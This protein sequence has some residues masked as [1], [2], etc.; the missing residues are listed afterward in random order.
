[1]SLF[2]DTDS[3]GLDR[4]NLEVSPDERAVRLELR[5]RILDCTGCEL[6]TDNGGPVPFHGPTPAAVAVVGEAPGAEETKQGRPFIGPAG[7]LLREEMRNAGIDPDALFWANTVSCK[8]P[9]NPT[10]EHVNACSGNLT[11][12]LELADPKWVLLVGGVA[13]GAIRPDL[14]VSKMRGHC[15]HR[16][17]RVYYSLFHPAFILRQQKMRPRLAADLRMFARMLRE[18]NPLA[19]EISCVGCGLDEEEIGEHDMAIHFDAEAVP[20]CENCVG[21]MP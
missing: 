16:G 20:Y 5:E 7:E 10:G 18:D 21:K 19:S 11:A 2:A 6:H 3:L 8:P 9:T 17:E 15:I 13:L 12:Q 14:K 4:E 1:M